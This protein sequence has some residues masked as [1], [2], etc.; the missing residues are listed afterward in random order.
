M[1]LLPDVGGGAR[2]DGRRGRRTL[3]RRRGDGGAPPPTSAVLVRRRADM[4]A[5]AAALRARGLP[6]EVVGLGGLLGTPEVRELVSA[7]RLVA[8]PLAGPAAVRLLTGARWRLGV[9]DIAALWSRARELAPRHRRRPPRLIGA[10][11]SWRSALCRP[12][13]PNRPGS[14]TRWT[15]RASPEQLLAGGVRPHPAAGRRAGPAAGPRVGAR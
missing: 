10:R 8:D 11:T 14:W 13:T 5:V 12:S 7:L 9:A 4:D 6:V 2:L 1:A 3:W 15:T